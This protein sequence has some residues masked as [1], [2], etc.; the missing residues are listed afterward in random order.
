MTWS[1]LPF[2][3]LTNCEMTKTLNSYISL[4]ISTFTEERE[5]V[6]VEAIIIITRPNEESSQQGLVFYVNENS[7]QQ[8]FS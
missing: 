4:W 2:K 8:K 6:K 3:P 1:D 5:F 7:D